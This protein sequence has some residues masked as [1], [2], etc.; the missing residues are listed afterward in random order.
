MTNT[1]STNVTRT[2]SMNSDNMKVRYKINTHISHMVLLLIM[3]PL[4]IAILCYHYKK[5]KSKKNND[6]LDR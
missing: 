2:V 1:L 3:L 4:I 6:A 5:H